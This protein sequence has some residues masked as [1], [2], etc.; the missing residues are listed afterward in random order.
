MSEAPPSPRA[1]HLVYPTRC[2]SLPSHPTA[3]NTPLAKKCAA[4]MG[5]QESPR[6]IQRRGTI[7]EV[8][9]DHSH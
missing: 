8:T 7:T 2:A 9:D 3:T 4:A 6:K 5:A 1:P